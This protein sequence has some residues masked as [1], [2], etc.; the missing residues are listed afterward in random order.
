MTK[1]Y[2][3]PNYWMS[4]HRKWTANA[5]WKCS[6]H[7][8][9]TVYLS[10]ELTLSYCHNRYARNNS[11]SRLLPAS[12]QLLVLGSWVFRSS[13]SGR[14]TIY[15]QL[16]RS[17]WTWIPYCRS[18]VPHP[19]SIPP[20]TTGTGIF[21]RRHR[22]YQKTWWPSLSQKD[23]ILRYYAAKAHLV[24]RLRGRSVFLHARSADFCGRRLA[25]SR[26]PRP[27]I[28]IRWKRLRQDLYAISNRGF[29]RLLIQIYG[30]GRKERRISV[31]MLG[32]VAV[33]FESRS[34]MHWIIHLLRNL[35][36]Y[37]PLVWV[38][39]LS[40]LIDKFDFKVPKIKV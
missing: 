34:T 25:V 16:E 19:P 2:P 17:Y 7:C 23:T 31:E 14:G 8:Q 36:E 12:E 3:S 10:F 32:G 28:W 18:C 40:R 22:I 24:G 20:Q 38:D 29:Q 26:S 1:P 13:L 35:I 6:D 9:Y 27:W 21:Q 30:W 39:W 37:S 33:S 11:R 15:T 5:S 4:P